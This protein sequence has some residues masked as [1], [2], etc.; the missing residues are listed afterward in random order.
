LFIIL[1]NRILRCPWAVF[2][3]RLYQ[4]VGTGL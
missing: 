1:M 4:S 2:L 3:D